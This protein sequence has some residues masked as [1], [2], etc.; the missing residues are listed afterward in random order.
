MGMERDIVSFA[1]VITQSGKGLKF[2]IMIIG[3][4]SGAPGKD[5]PVSWVTN[6]TTAVEE[7]KASRGSLV[8]EIAC[9]QLGGSR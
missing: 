8:A 4:A 6:S 3:I 1:D 9:S 5:D 7:G 2:S